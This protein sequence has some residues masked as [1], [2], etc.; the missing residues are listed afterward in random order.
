MDFLLVVSIV[1]LLAWSAYLFMRSRKK[2]RQKGLLFYSELLSEF[3]QYEFSKS[4]TQFP[5]LSGIYEGYKVKLV[6]EADNLVFQRLPRLYLR[7]YIYVP[8]TVLLRLRKLDFETQSNH[9]FLPGTFEKRHRETRFNNQEYRLFLSDDPYPLNLEASLAELFPDSNCCAEMLFQKSFIRVTILLSKGKQSSYIM[10]RAADF[11]NLIFKREFF[12]THF[13][14]VLEL[15]KEL[16]Q[17]DPKT[18]P[19]PDEEV[20]NFAGNACI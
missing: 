13:Q 6:P 8:N 12:Q 18:P 7:I 1:L 16:H 14:A 3:Q 10:T 11:D 17:S 4:T 20:K 2:S 9:L 5:V 19:N 15:H